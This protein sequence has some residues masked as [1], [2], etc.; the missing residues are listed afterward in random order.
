MRGYL[1]LGAIA[2]VVLALSGAGWWIYAEGKQSGKAECQSERV[3]ASNEAQQAIDERDRTASEARNSMLDYLATQKP[4]IEI[5][6]H[7]TVERI[8]TVYK[9][10]VI[11]ADCAASVAR[12]DRVRLDLN[13]ARDRANA[14]VSG[15]RLTAPVT[16]ATDT[17]MAPDGRMGGSHDGLVRD[18]GQSVERIESLPV[19]LASIGSH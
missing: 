19:W 10:R 12:D 5:K 3:E 14:A 6:T 9:D 1:L 17:G 2:A 15:V 4:A 13:A 7:E 16:R 11:T 18:S 8:R